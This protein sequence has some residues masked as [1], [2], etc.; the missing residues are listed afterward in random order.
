MMFNGVGISNYLRQVII[1][2]LP[3]KDFFFL[4]GHLTTFRTSV[5]EVEP[6]LL[7]SYALLFHCNFCIGSVN[8][9]HC[10]RISCVKL[11]LV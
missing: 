1:N 5:T 2:I 9:G 6:I 11:N 4:F 7:L 8:S 10:Y 3:S